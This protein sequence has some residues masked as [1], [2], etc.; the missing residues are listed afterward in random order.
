MKPN[1]ILR[2]AFFKSITSRRKKGKILISLLFHKKLDEN[3]QIAAQKLS[4]TLNENF[5]AKIIG[6]ARKQKIVL[7]TD[8]VEETLNVFGKKY[9]Y[10]HVENSFTQPNAA[11]CEKMPRMGSR[12]HKKS[13]GDLLELYCGNGNFSIPLSQNFDKVLATEIAKPSVESAQHNIAANQIEN[14]KILRLSSEEFTQAWN[15]ERIFNRLKDANVDFG[16]YQLETLFVDPPRSGLDDQ[17]REM[18]QNF[19]QLLHISCNPDTLHRDLEELTK[20]YKIERIAL[21]DQFFTH[22]AEMG[23]WLK[24]RKRIF[25]FLLINPKFNRLENY[26]TKFT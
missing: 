22:H 25:P 23:V 6:R 19:K 4:E 9:H 20:T 11:V 7:S 15:G 10:I 1:E 24:N 5:P 16:N 12:L 14:L 2:K 3:W 18:A 8:H 17:T 13:T 21:F 26:R